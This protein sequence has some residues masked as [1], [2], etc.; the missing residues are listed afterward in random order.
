MLSR[1]GY[2]GERH[3]PRGPSPVVRDSRVVAANT[4]APSG[5]L[6]GARTG[7]RALEQ[8]GAAR[9]SPANPPSR[10][11]ADSGTG[12]SSGSGFVL[13]SG[14]PAPDMAQWRKASSSS[15]TAA[16]P[17][18]NYA[19]FPLSAGLWGRR[20]V[21]S[22]Y[23]VLRWNSLARPHTCRRARRGN[24][25]HSGPVVKRQF[26]CSFSGRC[27]QCG[28]VKLSVLQNC[29]N[30][31][32]G[33]ALR[34][35]AFSEIRWRMNPKYREQSGGF[36]LAA[37]GLDFPPAPCTECP[38]FLRQRGRRTGTSRF[39]SRNPPTSQDRDSG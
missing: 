31:L 22:A 7:S 39:I 15:L 27:R 34:A 24:F 25:R 12:R 6:Q 8:H 37:A 23:V 1:G 10:G 4:K 14:L 28:R 30:A 38:N 32:L 36:R 35:F 5:T 3:T 2:S 16:G 18:R 11:R 19:G 33:N 13:G 9:R 26:G 21:T 29:D 17:P 20:P